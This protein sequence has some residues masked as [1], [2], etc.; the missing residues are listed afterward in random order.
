MEWRIF[1]HGQWILNIMAGSLRSTDTW[2]D[3]IRRSQFLE[4][5]TL[6]IDV[7]WFIWMKAPAFYLCKNMGQYHAKYT[8]ASYGYLHGGAAPGD[9]IIYLLS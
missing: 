6:E 8:C 2:R 7:F 4:G 9:S 1:P 3:I 5:I